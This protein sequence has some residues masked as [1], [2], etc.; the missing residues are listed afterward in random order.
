[1]NTWKIG[2]LIGVVGLQGCMAVKPADQTS[3]QIQAFQSKEFETDKSV[4]FAAVMS[5]FQDL[6]YIVQSADKET[7]FITAASP[8]KR[9]TNFFEALG[10]VA[11]SGETKATAFIEQI[12][13]GFANV[14]L[15]FVNTKKRSSAYGQSDQQDA[16]ILEPKAYQIAFEK[17]DD[18]IF[19]RAGTKPTK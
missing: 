10:G 3:L 13:P 17:I 4:A 14:R 18:A 15:N 16:P 5:V 7:G 6:G 12:R 9:N 11:S 19:I 1:M 2:V 8:T